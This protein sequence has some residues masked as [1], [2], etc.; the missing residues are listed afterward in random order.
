VAETVP[1][2]INL[3]EQPPPPV[4]EITLNQPGQPQRRLRHVRN[5]EGQITE[6]V[7]EDIPPAAPAE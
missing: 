6:S 5:A 2:T 1:I 3:P 4:I 7:T